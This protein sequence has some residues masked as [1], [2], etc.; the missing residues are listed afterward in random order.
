MFLDGE[1]IKDILG[2]L[3]PEKRQQRGVFDSFWPSLQIKT[4]VDWYSIT[5]T[6]SHSNF[7]FNHR[8]EVLKQGA[9]SI[10]KVYPTSIRLLILQLR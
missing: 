6:G 4:W 1:S 7:E 10:L 8:I 3:P 2:Y 9:G 5:S